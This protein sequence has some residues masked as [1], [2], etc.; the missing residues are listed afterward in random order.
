M[1][2]AELRSIYPLK[3]LLK[4]SGLARST[5]YYYLKA[6]KKDKYKELKEEIKSLS[7]DLGLVKKGLQN[8]LYI[9]LVHLHDDYVARGYATRDNKRDYDTLY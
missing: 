2:V 4:L 9:D 5:F 8:D 7:D 3:D 6:K 1:I